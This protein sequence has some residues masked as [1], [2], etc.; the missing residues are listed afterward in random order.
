MNLAIDTS[1]SRPLAAAL[2]EGRV[3][4]S[5]QGPSG[6]FHGEELLAGIDANLKAS[7]TKLSNLKMISVGIGPG[8]F[9][10]LRIGVT[11]AKFLA[12]VHGLP[13]A[14]VSSLH[15]QA[16]S[17][18]NLGVE[19]KV[20]SLT[21]AKRREVYALSVELHELSP[22]TIFLPNRTSAI[23]PEK[24][25]TL[26]SEKDLLVGEGAENYSE[27]WPPFARLASPEYRYLQAHNIGLIGLEIAKRGQLQEAAS[28]DALYLRTEKF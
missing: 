25:A 10:G 27:F 14:A 7:G 17:A 8:T 20:W 19:G 21:D 1:T 24:F 26:I 16:L 15:A 6:T 18:I 12:D 11:M 28:V 13:I 22:K 9:T 23:S 2:D 3:V 4:F 5:W